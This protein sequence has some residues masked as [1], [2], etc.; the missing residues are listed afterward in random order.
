ME[1]RA[2]HRELVDRPVEVH[3]GN[4]LGAPIL[5]RQIVQ[6]RRFAVRFDDPRLYHAICPVRLL[7]GDLQLL[8]R[9]S[10]EPIGVSSINIMPKGHNQPALLGGGE[11]RL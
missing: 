2:M 11:I 1:L 6:P 4:P 3:I 8:T 9:I 10:I 5:A 7:T